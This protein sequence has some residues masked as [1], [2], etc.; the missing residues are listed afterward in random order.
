MSLSASP[1]KKI[2]S[3]ISLLIS[4]SYEIDYMTF[5][6]WIGLWCSLFC[7]LIVAFDLSAI[8]R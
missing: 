1:P 2:L 4:S 8:V 5:R 6:L 3:K 7:L